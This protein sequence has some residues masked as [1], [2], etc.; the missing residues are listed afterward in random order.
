MT[1][2]EPL[3]VLTN[4]IQ[5]RKGGQFKPSQSNRICPGPLF[6]QPDFDRISNIRI[7]QEPLRRRFGH[8]IDFF[9]A[10]IGQLLF[11][12]N[13]DRRVPEVGQRVGE[14]VNF[15]Q[16]RLFGLSVEAAAAGRFANPA[17]VFL[18]NE[19]VIIFAVRPAPGKL[20]M[21]I[22]TPVI[23]PARFRLPS[24]C[25]LWDTG[26]L[27]LYPPVFKALPVLKTGLRGMKKG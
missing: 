15:G 12:D 18:L 9:I 6:A 16:R 11:G 14:A 23:L 1:A 3:F 24:I 19:A 21:M 13:F 4:Q 17:A 22:M 2:E 27:R 5:F 7:I 25:L 20:D 8:V 10:A 26:I